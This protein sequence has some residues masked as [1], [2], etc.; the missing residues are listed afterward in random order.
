MSDQKR[1]MFQKIKS[2][3]QEQFFIAM[4]AMY[5]DAYELGEAH[6]KQAVYIETPPRIQKKIEAAAERMR[7]YD[8]IAKRGE[9]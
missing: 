4:D 5:A 6:W 8:G 1:R 7:S 2:M 3:T 9:L